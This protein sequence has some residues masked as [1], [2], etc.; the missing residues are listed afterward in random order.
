MNIF[1]MVT[2]SVRIYQTTCKSDVRIIYMYAIFREKINKS[3]RFLSGLLKSVD[4]LR[5]MFRHLKNMI[6]FH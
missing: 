3:E 2:I 1:D 6:Q 4:Y 5:A